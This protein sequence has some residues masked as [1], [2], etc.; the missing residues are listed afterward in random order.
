MDGYKDVL[1]GYGYEVMQRDGFRCVYCG[2]DGSASFDAWL[3]LVRQFLRPKGDPERDN[4]EFIAT[5]CHSCALAD[6]RPFEHGAGQPGRTR[7]ELIEQRRPWVQAARQPY[8]D[9]WEAYVHSQHG[10][11]SKRSNT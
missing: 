5:V 1:R 2:F 7:A 3:S 8:R 6:T 4:P 9:F 11:E 10:Q